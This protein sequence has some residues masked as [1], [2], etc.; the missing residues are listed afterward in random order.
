[1]ARVTYLACWLAGLQFVKT[2]FDNNTSAYVPYLTAEPFDHC[3]P[4]PCKN[5]GTCVKDGDSFHCICPVDYL[6]PD[7]AN[8]KS[9][10]L[11]LLF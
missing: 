6:L 5:G 1:M 10:C 11:I 7:C 8:S 2:H 3:I 9:N 4:N